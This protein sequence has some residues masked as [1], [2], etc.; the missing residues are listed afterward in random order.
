MP[1]TGDP[2]PVGPA[3]DVTAAASEPAGAAPILA[4]TPR[5]PAVA[6]GFG[7]A[8]I[9]TGLLLSLL[10]H[11]TF[12]LWAVG[13]WD[14]AVPLR[15][16]PPPSITVDLVPDQEPPPAAGNPFALST[17]QPPPGRAETA[18]D[19]AAQETPQENP[20]QPPQDPPQEKPPEASPERSMAQAQPTPT[21]APL[22]PPAPFMASEDLAD[23]APD[24]SVP[25]PETSTAMR[26]AQSLQLP[27]ILPDSEGGAI[28][29][30]A[31]AKLSG[32]VISQFKEHVRGC[33]TT[34]PGVEGDTRVK[35]LVR[36]A[37]RRDGRI[38]DAPVLIQAVASPSG[39]AVVKSAITALQQ[40]QPYSFLPAETYKEW[41]VLDIGFSAQGVL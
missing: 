8:A 32:S 31:K 6:N 20:Q 14:I 9:A 3:A 15:A 25:P 29:A 33:W 17:R 41:R 11:A 36:V 19:Q 2:E 35:V 21:S 22:V 13:L 5:T 38:V 26:L 12:F 4:A 18:Q 7:V 16:A 1:P 39:P 28:P 30:D 10:G 24:D 23:L 34:P 37:L 27:V 40:C